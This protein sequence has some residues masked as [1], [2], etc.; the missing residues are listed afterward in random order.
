M[1]FK[2]TI[3]DCGAS[4]TQSKANVFSLNPLKISKHV[5]FAPALVQH[6]KNLMGIAVIFTFGVGHIV[7]AYRIPLLPKEALQLFEFINH[8][9]ILSC[10]FQGF[11]SCFVRSFLSPSAIRRRVE[12]GWITSSI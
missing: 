3:Y 4:A 5:R 2:N 6:L 12:C 1:N 7:D 9:G 8:N 10:F 11:S